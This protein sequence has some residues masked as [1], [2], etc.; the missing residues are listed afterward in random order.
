[1]PSFGKRSAKRLNSCH[2][3]LIRLFERVVE[4][5][6]CTIMTGH[7]GRKPQ[8]A[9]FDAG[10]SKLRFPDGKHN[11]LPSMAVD[12]A[13]YPVNWDNMKRFYHFAGYVLGIA[14]EMG[15]II[16]WGGDWDRDYVIWFCRLTDGSED[17][18]FCKFSYIV[19]CA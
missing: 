5:Y 16:R 8:N 2:V 1:M 13:P 18:R 4:E 19:S 10:N 6:D 17:S 12:A 14:K 3:D 11:A 7:R 9:A 15:L